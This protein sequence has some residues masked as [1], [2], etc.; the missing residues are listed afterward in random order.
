MTRDEIANIA[1]E[2]GLPAFIYPE[3]IAEADW[4]NIEAFA[5]LVA[6][7]ERDE[8][9]QFIESTNLGSLPE[10]TALHYA[11]LLRSYSTAIRA[12]GEA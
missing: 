4:K 5:K 2:A 10:E 1:V 12:R 6:A 3:L 8:I 11:K 7:K 9:V